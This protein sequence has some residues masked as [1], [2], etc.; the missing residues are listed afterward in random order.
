MNFENFQIL[1][2]TQHFTILFLPKLLMVSQELSLMRLYGITYLIFVTL[3][4]RE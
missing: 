2:Q 1:I 4:G 3:S